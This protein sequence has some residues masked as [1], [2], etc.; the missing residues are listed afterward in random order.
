MPAPTPISAIEV[1]SYPRSPKIAR[2]ASRIFSR[3]GSSGRIFAL[4][5]TFSAYSTVRSNY[6]IGFD[7]S[8]ETAS[9]RSCLGTVKGKVVVLTGASSGIG[10]EA[11]RILAARGA[12]L[13]L[14]AR[15]EERLRRLADELSDAGH[16]RPVVIP[17]DLARPGVAADVAR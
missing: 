10:A 14:I 5:G 13:A 8:V 3:P 9:R 11:A 2:A 7:R 1:A 17:A 15:G 4:R 12:R 16:P 6:V